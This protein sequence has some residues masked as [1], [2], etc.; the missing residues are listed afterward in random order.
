[1]FLCVWINDSFH[2]P[3][4]TNSFTKLRFNILV[5]EMDVEK[6]VKILQKLQARDLR[7]ALKLRTSSDV[8]RLVHP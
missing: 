1:M 6:V 4:A 3:R 5:R 7:T 2:C 8:G